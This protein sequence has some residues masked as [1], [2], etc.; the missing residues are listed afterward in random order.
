LVQALQ[1]VSLALAVAATAFVLVLVLRR[2]SLAREERQRVAIEERLRDTALALVDGDEVALPELNR[3]EAAVFAGLL[4]RYSRQLAGEPREHIATY[5]EDGGH[6]AH[7]VKALRGRRSWKR[8]AAAAVL[9]D[10]ASPTAVPALLDALDDPER[11]VRASAA[12]SLALLRAT[13]AVEPL[14]EA[15]AAG[16][17]QRAVG[18]WALMQMGEAAVP[19]LRALLDSEDADVR[20]VAAELLGLTGSAADSKVLIERLRDPRAEVR[21]KSA[22][23]LGRL[24][25]A[26]AATALRDVL[27]DRIFF[28]RAAAARALGQIGDRP[29]SAAL[30]HIAQTD[31]FEAAQAAARALA[32]LEPMGLEAAASVEAAKDH[33]REAAALAGLG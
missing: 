26:D 21:A 32:E 11:D 20:A 22:H 19:Q 6:V 17:L 1:Y 4:N 23:A 29:S 13:E 18:G 27:G 33:L 14:V 3:T 10:M 2:V 16:R 9:G 8:A 31:R 25:A 28:V 12:R 5:F 7:E 24:G 15:L 30:V